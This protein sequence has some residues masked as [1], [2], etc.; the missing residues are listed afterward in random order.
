MAGGLASFSAQGVD[1]QG[2]DAVTAAVVGAALCDEVAADVAVVAG[3]VAVLDVGLSEVGVGV[4]LDEVGVGVGVALVGVGVGVGVGDGCVVV[5]G[6]VVLGA[7]GAT[8][9]TET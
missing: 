3:G 4:G 1:P 9:V 5:W 8:V 2:V 7:G 6:A